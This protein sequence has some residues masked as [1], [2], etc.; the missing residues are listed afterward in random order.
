MSVLPSAQS[1]ES[2][3]DL[4]RLLER[5]DG[6]PDLLDALAGR[7]SGTIDGAWN[8]AAA[9]AAAA[10]ALRV[11]KSIVIVLAHAGDVEPWSH[12]L[13]SFSG[14]R[15]AIFPAWETWP[16]DRRPLD[17]VPGQRLRV[18]QKLSSEA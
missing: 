18:L 5:V 4:P 1:T 16:P 14:Q 17:E 11:P 9:L 15:A 13:H 2:L 7:R 10:L 12:D 8:S 6:W 3:T